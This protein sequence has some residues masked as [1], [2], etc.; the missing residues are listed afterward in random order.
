M[1]ACPRVPLI[2]TIPLTEH[3]NG[4]IYNYRLIW[5]CIDRLVIHLLCFWLPLCI[6]NFFF[7]Q[8]KYVSREKPFIHIPNALWCMPIWISYQQKNEHFLRNYHNSGESFCW[9]TMYKSDEEL[10][11]E[12]MGGYCFTTSEQFLITHLVTSNLLFKYIMTRTSYFQW[13]D[14][15]DRFV[16]EQHA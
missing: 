10:V 9:I 3:E 13:D 5:T 7:K 16:L 8:V 12:W 14:E 6:F 15:D 4:D 11:H 1:C 2:Y